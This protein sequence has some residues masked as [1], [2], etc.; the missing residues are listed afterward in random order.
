MSATWQEN[1][2][3]NS[4]RGILFSDALAVQG[5]ARCLNTSGTKV[6][7]HREWSNASVVAQAGRMWRE[8]LCPG[9]CLINPGA[10]LR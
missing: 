4:T 3:A 9:R 8:G 5:F 6:W 7:P 2:S 1:L 10:T